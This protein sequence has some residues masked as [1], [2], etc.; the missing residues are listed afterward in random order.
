MKIKNL[1]FLAVFLIFTL[2]GCSFFKYTE[3]ENRIYATALGIDKT[4]LGYIL[5]CE[6]ADYNSATLKVGEIFT[7]EGVSL[8]NA[9]I[10]LKTAMHKTPVFSKCPVVFI[11]NSVSK[12][13]IYDTVLFL[14]N[15]KE[16]SFSVRTVL[17]ENANRLLNTKTRYNIPRGVL[18]YEVIKK[19]KN[20]GDSL[21]VILNQNKFT[22][23][24]LSEVNGIL[25]ITE[26]REFYEE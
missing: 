13:L 22:L 20:K 17:T 19:A 5:T 1:K 24:V 23:P 26:T 15:E 25:R 2:C 18:A 7:A 4:N 10:E 21:A 14:L 9:F 16:F 8:E 6:T 3:P 12:A 11:G